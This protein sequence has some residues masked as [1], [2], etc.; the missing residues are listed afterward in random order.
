MILTKRQFKEEKSLFGLQFQVTV[1]HFREVKPGT[2]EAS[3]ITSLVKSDK[4]T[5]ALF[6]PS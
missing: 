4:Y 5:L 6:A 3:H 2:E 1:D